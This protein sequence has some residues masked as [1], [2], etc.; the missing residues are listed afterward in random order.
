MTCHCSDGH[1]FLYFKG[2]CPFKFKTYDFS[3]LIHFIVAWSVNVVAATNYVLHT[4]N[5]IGSGAL[6]AATVVVV[7]CGVPLPIVFPFFFQATS[8]H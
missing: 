5:H 6:Q 1:L 8:R 3:V 4:G 2:P 7:S